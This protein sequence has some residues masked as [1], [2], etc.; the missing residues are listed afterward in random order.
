MDVTMEPKYIGWN[1]SGSGHYKR[2]ACCEDDKEPSGSWRFLNT[3]AISCVLA[4]EELSAPQTGLCSTSWRSAFQH[5]DVV[6]D[7]DRPVP[8]AYGNQCTVRIVRRADRMTGVA[9]TTL[10]G[11][12]A[13][14]VEY[15]SNL[16][17]KP[18]EL[19]QCYIWSTALRG[20]ETGLAK[21]QTTNTWKVLKCGAG[22]GW[23]RPVGPIVWE[24][25]KCYS[26]SGRRGISYIQ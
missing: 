19:V 21:Q 11:G 5:A 25:K 10:M 15:S 13:F 20:A 26:A 9:A 8:A 4:H 23:R 24:T 22:E 12:Q 17:N 3:R 6:T 1:S 2:T 7:S 16:K 18:Y 14:T